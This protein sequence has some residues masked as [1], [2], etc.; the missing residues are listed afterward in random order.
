MMDIDGYNGY[1]WRMNIVSW[2]FMPHS[3]DCFAN[4][5]VCWSHSALQVVF[6]IRGQE[7]VLLG[8]DAL[9]KDPGSCISQTP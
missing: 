1:E 6:Y 5:K 9:V 4:P 7:Y 8:M 2:C 3:A